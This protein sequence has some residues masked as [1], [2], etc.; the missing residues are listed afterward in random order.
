MDNSSHATDYYPRAQLS[1][2]LL[3][4]C[5]RHGI[6]SQGMAVEAGNQIVVD[7]Q[8]QLRTL[9]K[10]RSRIVTEVAPKSVQTVAAFE[11][12]EQDNLVRFSRS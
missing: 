3:L 10:G 9:E 4:L 5:A 8:V 1:T 7:V 2:K 11:N 6:V 12:C